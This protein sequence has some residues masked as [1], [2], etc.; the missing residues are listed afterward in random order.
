MHILGGLWVGL[1]SLVSYYSLFS[2]KSK[3]RSTI[4]VVTFAIAATLL[5]GVGWEIFEFEVDKH[6]AAS[7]IDLGDTLHDLVNDFI[8]A[9]I[10]AMIFVRKGYNKTI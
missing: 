3:E 5:V 10:A 9:C 2:G 6:I 1:F 8:G 4:F 7:G